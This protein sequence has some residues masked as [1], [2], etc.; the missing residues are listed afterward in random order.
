MRALLCLLLLLGPFVSA[1]ANQPASEF[2][3]EFIQNKKQWPKPVLFAAQLP[4]G[5]L[6]LEQNRLTYNFLEP[7]Y[8]NPELSA[9]TETN[10]ANK[11]EGHAFQ[12]NFVNANPLSKVTPL[13]K[14]PGHRNYYIGNDAASWATAVPAYGEIKYTGLFPR[15]DLRLYTAGRT[16][17]YDYVVAPQGQVSA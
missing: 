8:F 7:D 9:A 10:P 14:L 13:L 11:Y 3:T 15:I 16:L 2:S 5:W 12:I 17:K 4:Q 1:S 6:F